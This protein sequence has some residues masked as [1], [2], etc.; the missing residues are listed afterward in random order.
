M[1]WLRKTSVYGQDGETNDS[2]QSINIYSTET[3]L[4]NARYCYHVY[5]HILPA[6]KIPYHT[7]PKKN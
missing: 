5:G 4:H 6:I 3:T 1:Y 7:T 2:V